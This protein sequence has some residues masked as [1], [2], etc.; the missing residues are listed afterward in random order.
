MQNNAHGNLPINNKCL[1]WPQMSG[2]LQYKSASIS[3]KALNMTSIRCFVILVW[4]SYTYDYSLRLAHH[5]K[6]VSFENRD[7]KTLTTGAVFVIHFNIRD[8]L[9][10]EFKLFIFHG[11]EMKLMYKITI[12]VFES[13]NEI[14]PFIKNAAVIGKFELPLIRWAG[15]STRKI[16]YEIT[17]PILLSHLS[18]TNGYSS[19]IDDGNNPPSKTACTLSSPYTAQRSC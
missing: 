13:W 6:S 16:T 1:L 18:I 3:K 7:I 14:N 8:R 5:S 17:K 15:C 2:Q 4:N 9:V 11:I 19:S 12:C 10:C